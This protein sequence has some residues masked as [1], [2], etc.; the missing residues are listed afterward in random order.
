MN[1][2]Q[3]VQMIIP[4]YLK[5]KI[6]VMIIVLNQKNIP[7]LLIKT[8]KNVLKGVIQIVHINIGGKVKYVLM[9]V[10]N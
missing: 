8:Q 6:F 10:L 5:M 2:I 4:I 3:L 7:L 1:V 9:T